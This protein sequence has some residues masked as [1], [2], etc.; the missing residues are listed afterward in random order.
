MTASPLLKGKDAAAADVNPP[1]SPTVPP[2]CL[3]PFNEN[4]CFQSP[5]VVVDPCHSC[6]VENLKKKGTRREAK[7]PYLR[8]TY[9]CGCAA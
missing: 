6:M 9:I 2:T 4:W 5:S 7:A 3:F 8:I 1:R